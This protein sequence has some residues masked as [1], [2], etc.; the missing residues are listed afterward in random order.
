MKTNFP[1]FVLLFFGHL[2]MAQHSERFKQADRE[3]HALNY[4]DAIFH[5][6]TNLK[7]DPN[8]LLALKRLAESYYKVKNY[9]EAN[10]VYTLLSDFEKDSVSTA[11]DKL[12]FAEVLANNEGYHRS[13][14]VYEEYH[15]EKSSDARGTIFAEAYE[16]PDRIAGASSWD[17]HYLSINTGRDEYSPTYYKDGL[18]FVSNREHGITKKRVFS[19][20]HTPFVDMYFAARDQIQ[21][22]PIDSLKNDPDYRRTVEKF[23]YNDD[24]TAFTSNDNSIITYDTQYL[25]DT[26]GAYLSSI[27]RVQRL[28]GKLNSKY[29][30]GPVAVVNDSTL[31]LTRNNYYKKKYRQSKDRINKL[32][33]YVGSRTKNGEWNVT[34]ALPFNDDEHSVGHPALS[35]DG[36]T[37]YFSSDASG[38][39]GGADIYRSKRDT[40]GNWG[41]PEN[42][43]SA[44][45]TS[46]DELFPFVDQKNQLYFASNGLPGY[47]GLDLFRI[48]LKTLTDPRNLPENMGSPLN[49]SK[50][51]FGLILDESGLEGYLSSNR[52][53]N[54]DIYGIENRAIELIV[55]VAQSEDGIPVEG[56]DIVI[57]DGTTQ[58][59]QQ[60]TVDGKTVFTLRP[61]TEYR[62]SA[63][64]NGFVSVINTV[65]TNQLKGGETL[66]TSF[67]LTPC[68]NDYSLRSIY[69]DFDKYEVRNEEKAA[70]DEIVTLMDKQPHLKIQISSHTDPRGSRAYNELLSKRR[71]EATLAYLA[72]GGIDPNRMALSFYGESQLTNQCADGVPCNEIQQQ[73]NRRSDIRIIN[74]D[75]H[76]NT[77]STL[78]PNEPVVEHTPKVRATLVS[79]DDQTPLRDIQV[80]LINDGEQVMSN[81]DEQGSVSFDLEYD[82]TYELIFKGTRYVTQR[83]Y[84]STRGIPN[85]QLFEYTIALKDVV[86]DER[87]KKSGKPN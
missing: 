26:I 30:D 37:L 83:L 80:I 27:T 10:R 74:E 39:H 38:G 33:L 64:K 49:S 9:G 3:F 75:L 35:P 67:E 25:N 46:G 34:G 69:F 18:L 17:I 22:I 54:D 42:L 78:N 66:N 45:N 12:N 47:G 85:D 19:W 4:R 76:L 14:K 55:D 79:E 28:K 43:G 15:K 11:Q 72:S 41:T 13:Q 32:K 51:D 31:L 6:E 40:E 53:G 8:N 16:N 56:A 5:Y 24:N 62:V 82:T 59:E 57:S 81:T 20:N 77:C 29:H 70:L 65:S 71:A 68:L 58:L 23:I 63:S 2:L 48:D 52:R 60:T 73:M 86:L 21:P 84:I 87:F 44:I 50:D 7:E 36:N 61:D 1:F